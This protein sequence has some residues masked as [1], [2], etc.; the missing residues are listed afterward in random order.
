MLGESEARTDILS[1]R[2]LYPDTMFM[3]SVFSFSTG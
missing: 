3:K 1:D 2:D